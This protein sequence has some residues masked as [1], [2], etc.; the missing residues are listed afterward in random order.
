MQ[1]AFQEKGDVTSHYG[2]TPAVNTQ[3]TGTTTC[4]SNEK[5]LRKKEELIRSYSP[6]ARLTAEAI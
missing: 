5:R 2:T 1:S 4:T 3:S 6:Y